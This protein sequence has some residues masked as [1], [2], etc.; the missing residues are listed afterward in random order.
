MVTG[1]RAAPALFATARAGTPR[2]A[3]APRGT[4]FR[5]TLSEAARVTLTIQRRRPGRRP[6]TVGTLRRSA[7]RGTNSTRFTGRIGT[8]ALSPG[9]YRALIRASD[10]A[11]NRSV[12]KATRFRIAAR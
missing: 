3:R 10:S 9:R 11:G 4:R 8:R 1:F 6:R 5:Y 12:R 7:G 2:A